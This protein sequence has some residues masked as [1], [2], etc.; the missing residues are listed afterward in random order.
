MIVNPVFFRKS[1]LSPPVVSTE[2]RERSYLV[3][4]NRFA[5]V[6]LTGKAP[7]AQV[8]TLIN[9]KL[10]LCGVPEQMEKALQP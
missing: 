8:N 4:V 1:F 7:I 10:S 5:V 6:F 3:S 2:N 9:V